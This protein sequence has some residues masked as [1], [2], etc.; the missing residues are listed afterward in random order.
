MKNLTR[1]LLNLNVSSQSF[2]GK[3][4][5][6]AL[7]VVLIVLSACSGKDS[8]NEV[9]TSRIQYDVPVVNNDPQLDWWINNI[10]GSKRE[11][12]LKRIMEAAAKGDVKVF[13]Y[14]SN[15]LTSSQVL[16][17]GTD[18]IFQTLLRTY[19]P[20]EEYDTMIVKSVS[21]RDIVR[22]RFMEEWNWN[23]ESLE[24]EKKV[25]AVGPVIQKEFAGESF[26]QLLFWISL[27]ERFPAK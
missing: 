3:K 6:W 4:S 5:I 12:F 15:P 16:A 2:I 14:F 13:D 7:I 10:E 25:L 20:Y 1:P 24:M 21:Y 22:I 26:S 23:P 11:P 17:I 27:D 8:K 19:P 9:L 18:T